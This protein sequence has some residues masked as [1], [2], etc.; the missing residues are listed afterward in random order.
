MKHGIKLVFLLGAVLAAQAAGPR[1]ADIYKSGRLSIVPDIGFG[2]GVDWE[3]QLFDDYQEIAVAPDGSVFVVDVHRDRVR[4]FS[5]DGRPLLTFGRSGQGPGDLQSPGSP[6]VLDGRFLVVSEYATLQRISLFDLQGRFVKVLKTERPVFDVVPLR[7]GRLAYLSTRATAAAGA[8][9]GAV[10]TVAEAAVAVKDVAT[11]AERVVWKAATSIDGI[12]LPNGGMMGFGESMR[13]TAF[14]Q[15]TAEGDLAVGFSAGRR[16]EIFSPQGLPRRSFDLNLAEV[17]VRPEHIERFRKTLFPA[18]G[19]DGRAASQRA[20]L[21]KV[22]LAPLFG[23]KL[24][25]Y[26]DFRMDSEG[27]FLFFLRNEDFAPDPI[28]IAAFS[29]LGQP[30]GRFELD[31]GALKISLDPRFRA[32]QFSARG[33][34]GLA[35]REDDP[36]ASPRLFRCAFSMGAKGVPDP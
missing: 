8:R 19:R 6:G 20:V 24:P 25:L 1:W 21:S 23:P 4:K 10:S 15:A 18:G 33:L 34:V 11:G 16:I 2:R 13:G 3:A 9:S 26:R 7:D 27:N 36:D 17:P 29:P 28:R 5:P 30:I 35:P 12:L 31:P 22:D 14:I 32:L